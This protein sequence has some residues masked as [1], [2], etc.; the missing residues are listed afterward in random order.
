[1]LIFDNL[2]HPLDTC[3]YIPGLYVGGSHSMATARCSSDTTGA[4]CTLLN[5]D[6]AEINNC[7]MSM[8]SHM[9]MYDPTQYP[10]SCQMVQLERIFTFNRGYNMAEN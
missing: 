6:N 9:Y 3:I 4:R 5:S 1:M 2:T 10:L 8:I 7:Y